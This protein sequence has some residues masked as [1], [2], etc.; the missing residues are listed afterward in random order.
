MKRQQHT[1]QSINVSGASG[2][3]TAP[4]RPGAATTQTAE[5]ERLERERLQRERLQR[6]RDCR[7]R[8]RLQSETAERE[9]AETAERDCSERLE[10]ERVWEREVRMLE[11]WKGRIREDRSAAVPVPRLQ[12][13][14]Q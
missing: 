8:E 3:S 10:R 6:E 2:L 13:S 4:P 14:N 11:G 1:S 5:R 7:E 9:T 12:P